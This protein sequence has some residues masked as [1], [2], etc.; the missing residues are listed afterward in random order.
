METKIQLILARIPS[1]EDFIKEIKIQFKKGAMG[2]E[3]EFVRV[4]NGLLGVTRRMDEIEEFRTLWK[5]HKDTIQSLIKRK[6]IP[7]NA[8]PSDIAHTRFY[9]FIYTPVGRSLY[10]VITLNGWPTTEQWKHWEAWWNIQLQR[11]TDKENHQGTK[12]VTSSWHMQVAHTTSMIMQAVQDVNIAAASNIAQIQIEPLIWK[13][14][15]IQNALTELHIIPKT[16]ETG[17]FANLYAVNDKLIKKIPTVEDM[18]KILTQITP[19]KIPE[20]HILHVSTPANDLMAIR[21]YQYPISTKDIPVP[22]IR[23]LQSNYRLN[24]DKKTTTKSEAPE[25][26]PKKRKSTPKKKESKVT[27]KKQ[28]VSSSEESQ[29]EDEPSSSDD[30]TENRKAIILG[31]SSSEDED[32]D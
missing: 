8:R 22:R 24:W 27:K 21:E 16:N 30:E 20:E 17:W 6:N 4:Q 19:A 18:R 31:S 26:K 11:I 10:Q 28:K 15:F 1:T 14:A 3:D 5:N 13:I 32:F 9:Q 25:I 12:S 2:S 23:S 29:S 7:F